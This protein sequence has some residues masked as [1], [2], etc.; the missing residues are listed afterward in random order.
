MAARPPPRPELEP[1]AREMVEHGH[2]LRHLGRMVDLRQRI[3][4][5]RAQMDATGGVGQIPEHDV[6][7]REVG[8]LV[9]EVVLGGPHILEA[10]LVGRD[11]A[12]NVVHDRLMLGVGV[13]LTPVHGHEAL[14]EDAEFHQTT[15]LVGDCICRDR[16]TRRSPAEPLWL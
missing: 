3:E 1:A 5:A 12:L 7:G 2:P 9:E 16:P 13:A 10:R 6:V 14:D 8:V 11:G 4:D 15:P